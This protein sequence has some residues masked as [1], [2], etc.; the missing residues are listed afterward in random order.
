MARPGVLAV[1]IVLGAWL[2]VFGHVGIA[3]AFAARRLLPDWWL[4]LLLGVAQIPLGVLALAVPG[5]TL[6]ALV[7]VA[8]IWAV[9]IGVMRIVIAFQVKRL[10]DV[11]EFAA[12]RNGTATRNG[13]SPAPMP[14]AQS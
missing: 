9:A 10:P 14:V 6:A 1:A 4:L 2:I 3:G 12:A 11:D 8:G 13:A 5:A 7:T